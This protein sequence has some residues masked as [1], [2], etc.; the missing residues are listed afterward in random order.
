MKEEDDLPKAE[1]DWEDEVDD[2]WGD[3]PDEDPESVPSKRFWSLGM[4]VLW[5]VMILLAIGVSMPLF[6]RKSCGGGYR[7]EAIGNAKQV[8]LALLE[9]DQDFGKFPDETTVAAVMKET[10]SDLDLT[11]H[12][13]NALFRQLIAYGIQGEDI[14]Y[15]K[16]PFTRMPDNVITPGEAL[17]AGE[18][19]FS[20]VAGLD[21]NQNPGLP[22]H[23]APMKIGSTSFY[24]ETFGGKVVVL[25]VDNSATAMP[26]R[27]SDDKVLLENGKMLFDSNNGLWAKGHVIDLRHPEKREAD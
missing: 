18:V 13:S 7:A 15:C 2:D 26:I 3:A 4:V 19:G 24:E 5:T 16:H 6:L 10:G 20:Y 23:A 21:T 1:D 22:L 8:G 11:G 12:S 25:R 14:F 9:F 17:R 27:S